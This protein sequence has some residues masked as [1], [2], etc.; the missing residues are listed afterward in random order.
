[1]KKSILICLLCWWGI[2]AYS[3]SEG[4]RFLEGEKWEKVLQMALEQHKYIF[5]DC[6]TSW[7]GPC[8]ALAKD[9]FSQKKVGDF[10]NA[11]FINVKYDMEKGEGKDLKKR[12][13]E[14]IIGYP[15]LLLLD[16]EGKVVHQMAGFQEADALIAGV[17]AGME[18][19]SLFVYRD[20]Y[21]AGE[22][23]L[24]F[25]KEYVS[26]L[27]AAFLRDEVE[28]VMTEYVNQL[29]LERLKDKEVWDLVG[30]YI[31]DPYSQAFEFVIFNLDYFPTK[32]KVDRY[33]LE[34]QLNWA[35]EKALKQVIELKK[36]KNGKILPFQNESGKLDT[37]LRLINRAN[38][39][40]AEEYR[41]KI[42]IHELMLAAQWSQVC[43][44][45]DVCRT[46]GALGYSE[47]YLD[48]VVQ[49]LAENCNDR[50]WLEWGL[51]LMEEVQAQENQREDR[52]K[53]SYYSTLAILNE[54]LGNSRKAKEYREMDEKIRKE[55]AKR[56]EELIK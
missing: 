54:R 13:Q 1:M 40:R 38:L 10:F 47:R 30:G 37:L 20:R 35:M 16:S 52:L 32:L 5:M 14:N 48:E 50:K 29:P 31:K 39:K 15:T 55:N 43:N 22:R 6:Y 26:A 42:K 36:D 21:A 3:Q 51:R 34:W 7:C 17:K 19:K 53:S 24:D 8:K 18:G 44:Y 28:K 4:I 11:N 23:E 46:I 45:L 33:K 41:A 2:G 49:Y 12:Y 25:M 9:I 27:E 56:W